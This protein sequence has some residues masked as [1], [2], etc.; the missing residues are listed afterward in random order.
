MQH[1]GALAAAGAALQQQ[2]LLLQPRQLAG[3]VG[4]HTVSGMCKHTVT[5]VFPC[6]QFLICTSLPAAHPPPPAAPP[7][8]PPLPPPPPPPQD[9]AAGLLLL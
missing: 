4:P 3:L 8:P 2:H 6:S 1:E 9:E 5:H 7:P